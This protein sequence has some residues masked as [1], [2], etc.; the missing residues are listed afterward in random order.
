MRKYDEDRNRGSPATCYFCCLLHVS[1]RD[2][3]PHFKRQGLLNLPL[4]KETEVVAW[5]EGAPICTLAGA[6]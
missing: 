2:K 4:G 6:L 3:K 5:G 1:H